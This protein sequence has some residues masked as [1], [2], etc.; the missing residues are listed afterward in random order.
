MVVTRDYAV[1]QKDCE[2]VKKALLAC[3]E[4]LEQPKSSL[5]YLYVY[6]SWSSLEA[7]M[8][9][10]AMELG[11]ASSPLH[12]KF[13]ATHDAWLGTPRIMV[14]TERMEAVADS[15][16]E[17]GLMHEAAHSILH[18][19]LE[20]YT[21]AVPQAL[22]DLALEQGFTKQL[23]VDLTYL[24]SIAVKDFEVTSYLASKGFAENQLSFL[25]HV[26]KPDKEDEEA[27]R[28]A[29]GSKPLEA[30]QAAAC[31]KSLACIAPLLPLPRAKRLINSVLEPVKKPYAEALLN[32][33]TSL[34]ALLSGSTLANLEELAKVFTQKIVSRGG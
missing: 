19:S 5:V 8:L 21:L 29:G 15:V 13:F 6:K 26:L 4:K 27:W 33:V 2:S 1:S 7:A 3:Y 25:E 34:N 22:L 9:K 14:S 11:V 17:G 23:I 30:L 28:I 31:L 12:E 24:L 10:E 32:V 18:G 20:Y 16:K